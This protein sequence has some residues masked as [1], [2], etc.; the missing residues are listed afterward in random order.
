VTTLARGLGAIGVLLL[1]ACAFTPLPER[2]ARWTGTAPRLA[3]ADA[4][5]VLGAE[6]LRDGSLS[7][8]S[9]RRTVHGIRLHRRGLAPL[10]VFSGPPPHDGRPGEPAVRAALARELGVAASAILTATAWTTAEEAEQARALLAD[11]GVRRVLLVSE[12]QHLARARRLFERAGFEVFPAPADG[13]PDADSPEARIDLIRGIL[14]E[15]AARLV[16]RVTGRW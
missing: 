2:L 3:P 15:L 8:I 11:R 6:A 12:S 16:Y 9:L 13:V 7:P 1:L 14:K 5:V 10:L 4:I